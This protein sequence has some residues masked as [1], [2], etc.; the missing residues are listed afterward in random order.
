MFQPE[1]DCARGG[2]R[3]KNWGD[4]WKDGDN[5]NEGNEENPFAHIEKA[6]NT[7]LSGHTIHIKQGTYESTPSVRVENKS[8]TFVGVDGFENTIIDNKNA[9]NH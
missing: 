3:T 9:G 2:E 6:A 5:N 4:R 7:A 1:R 8:L